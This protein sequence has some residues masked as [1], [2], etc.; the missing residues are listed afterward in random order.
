MTAKPTSDHQEF[1][2]EHAKRERR[3]TLQQRQAWADGL[4]ACLPDSVGYKKACTR[5]ARL[6]E[7][8]LLNQLVADWKSSL[9][10]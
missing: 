3:I 2:S 8:V 9:L 5:Q 6:Q 1:E 4:I 7:Q 10:K